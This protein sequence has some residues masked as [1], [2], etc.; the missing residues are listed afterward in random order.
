MQ[1]RINFQNQTFLINRKKTAWLGIDNSPQRA[2]AFNH[3]VF[4]PFIALKVE[5]GEI[6]F[7]SLVASDIRVG[8]GLRIFSHFFPTEWFH[9]SSEDRQ[10]FPIQNIETVNLVLA[11]AMKLKRNAL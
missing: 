2:P 4:K 6:V 7:E 8:H 9:R 10:N 5:I 11:V 1:H 3:G